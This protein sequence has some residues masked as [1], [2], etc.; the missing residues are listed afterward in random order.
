VTGDNQKRKKK[1]EV[2]VRL[3]EAAFQR[4]NEAERRVGK[5][6]KKTYRV[7][8]EAGEMR[9][10]RGSS[11]PSICSQPLV[12]AIGCQKRNIKKRGRNKERKDG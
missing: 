12:S 5:K 1:P 3:K 4:I 10:G 6:E 11:V 2:R 9:Q 7:K 8:E